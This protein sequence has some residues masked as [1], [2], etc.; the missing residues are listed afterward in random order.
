MYSLPKGATALDFAFQIHTE[1][2]IHTRGTKVN[3]KLVPLSRELMSGD[4]VEIIT[5]ENAKPTN[6][7]LNYATTGKAISKIKSALN[8]DKKVVAAEGKEVLVR[9]LKS[10]KIS[11]DENTTNQLVSFFK[12]KTSL[13][14][15][16]RVGSGIIDNKQLK[17]FAAS[18]SNA[19][20][21]FFKKIRKP[22]SPLDIHK[23]EIT[24]KY[25]QLVFGKEE[26]KLDY[27]MS[28]CC[29]PIPGD[30][31]FGFVTINEGIKVHKQNCP[32]AVQLQSNY[33]Y[34][35]ILATWIDSTQR[36]FRSE[37]SLTGIDTIGLV[38]EVTRVVSN[39]L[40]IDMKSVHF[41]SNDGVFTGKI[42][43]VVKNKN[44]L[45]NLV[46]NIK[47]INGIDKVTRV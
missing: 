32:N 30:N 29:N 44:I 28:T 4:Q 39:N 41:D 40:L 23:E 31:V 20:V 5:S 8:A 36:E 26:Q 14:L 43:V 12:L 42:V 15:F 9:K 21:S 16:F 7:W 35:I 46:Q 3:G 27:K 22:T 25:D 19:L 10:L 1:V 17:E 24:E 37:L 6:N 13:D 2:G 34:R 47:K 38:N 11:L 18:R 33:N 45:D